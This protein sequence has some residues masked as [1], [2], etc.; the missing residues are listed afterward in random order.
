MWQTG[1]ERSVGR[2]STESDCSTLHSKKSRGFLRG[3]VHITP[4]SAVSVAMGADS[5]ANAGRADA[6]ATT[7]PMAA[8]LD[9]TP[10]AGSISV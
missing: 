7:I 5:D 10:A 6:D 2:D 3:F 1:R 4:L 8:T 9:M